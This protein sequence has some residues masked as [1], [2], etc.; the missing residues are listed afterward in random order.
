MAGRG[1]AKLI[2]RVRIRSE[3]AIGAMHCAFATGGLPAAADERPVGV[4]AQRGAQRHRTGG[5]CARHT[6][7]K[8]GQASQRQGGGRKP[9]QPTRKAATQSISLWPKRRE[10]TG[11]DKFGMTIQTIHGESTQ[12]EARTGDR[13]AHVQPVHPVAAHQLHTEHEAM[14]Q[15]EERNQRPGQRKG[16]GRAVSQ[17]HS[18]QG[19]QSR[20]QPEPTSECG[21]VLW[22]GAH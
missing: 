7:R 16:R 19:K 6:N 21:L 9:A 18:E 13:V 22:Q 1:A 17:K 15:G 5:A 8:H 2:N 12:A 10:R 3:Q 14:R 20:T 4:R 11:A